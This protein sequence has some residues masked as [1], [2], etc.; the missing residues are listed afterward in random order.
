MVIE[1]D[2]TDNHVN[3]EEIKK[4]DQIIDAIYIRV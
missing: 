4:I 1:L 2:H 3:I